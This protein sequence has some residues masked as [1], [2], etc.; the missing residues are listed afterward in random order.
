MESF[1][2]C[3]LLGEILAQLSTSSD[4]VFAGCP[5]DQHIISLPNCPFIGPKTEAQG[6]VCGKPAEVCDA[7]ILP[8]WGGTTVLK[9]VAMS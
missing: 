7:E 9:P 2:I 5:L 1:V 4:F 3:S 6:L 8:T